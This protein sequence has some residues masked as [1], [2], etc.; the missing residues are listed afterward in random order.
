MIFFSDWRLLT[1]YFMCSHLKLQLQITLIFL[2]EHS[3]SVL[4]FLKCWVSDRSDFRNQ[5]AI[6]INFSSFI[7]QSSLLKFLKLN[8]EFLP[9]IFLPVWF[10]DHWLFHQFVSSDSQ[11]K[12]IKNFLWNLIL[13]NQLFPN[14]TLG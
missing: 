4:K 14:L 1:W 11:C 13:L 3:A 5:L 12:K 8:W 10:L 6:V 7:H 2:F 9:A